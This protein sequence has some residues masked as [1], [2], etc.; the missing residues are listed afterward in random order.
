MTGASTAASSTTRSGLDA[1]KAT[2]RLHQNDAPEAVYN[3]HQLAL[4]FGN[5]ALKKRDE[6]LSRQFLD[7]EHETYLQ[8]Q[9]IS[10]ELDSINLK[11]AL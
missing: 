10:G 4:S 2:V 1:A 7:V 11:S 9:T 3:P 8:Q 5:Q 6:H